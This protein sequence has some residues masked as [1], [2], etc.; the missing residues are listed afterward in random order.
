MRDKYIAEQRAL[1]IAALRDEAALKVNQA[2]ID[3]L[4]VPLPDS[5]TLRRLMQQG[6]KPQ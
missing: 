3:S 2:A 6:G 5:A 1:K 4:I